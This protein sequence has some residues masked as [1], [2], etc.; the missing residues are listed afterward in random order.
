[1]SYKTT[2]NLKQKKK[3]KNK[4]RSNYQ[5]DWLQTASLFYLVKAG[6]GKTLHQHCF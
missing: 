4:G 1:M 3:L 6:M 2:N 5:G